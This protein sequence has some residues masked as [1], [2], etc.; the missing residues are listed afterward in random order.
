M[1]YYNLGTHRRSVTTA[2]PDAQRWFDRGFAW[3]YSF[4]HEEGV[5]C[6]ERASECDPT[7]TMAFWGIAYAVGPN[8][9]KAWGLFDKDD[10]QSS[11]KKAN[12]ALTCAVKSADKASPIEKALVKA[13]QLDS[14]RRI[15]FPTT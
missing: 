5:R 8:Y 9:N 12:D 6:F 10:L 1:D 15:A 14:Q 11:I 13:L 3:S 7:C 4:N 2:S